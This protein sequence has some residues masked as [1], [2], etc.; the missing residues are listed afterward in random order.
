MFDLLQEELILNY[1]VLVYLKIVYL[2]WGVG[3]LPV[4]DFEC[5]LGEFSYRRLHSFQVN[6]RYFEIGC[7]AKQS[8][9]REDIFP[10]KDC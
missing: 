3:C 9:C 1:A 10:G 8:L 7:G 5:W 6:S 2:L 4:P